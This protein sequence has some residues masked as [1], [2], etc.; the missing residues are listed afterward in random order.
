MPAA[1]STLQPPDSRF[2][3]STLR[4]SADTAPPLRPLLAGTL[5]AVAVCVLAA[6]FDTGRLPLPSR[7]VFWLVLIGWNSAK[8]WMWY[9]WV[10]PRAVGRRG[11]LLLALAGT[12][13]LNAT[14]PLEIDLMFRAIGQPVAL[15]WLGLYL[16]ALVI[17][18]SISAFIAILRGGRP[19]AAPAPDAQPVAPP[20]PPPTTSLLAP[21]LLAQR[22]GLPDLADVRHVVAEDHYLRLVLAD[23]RRPLVLFR[24]GDALPEL[25]V[26]DGCQVH[27]SAWVAAAHVVGARR[28]GRRWLLQLAD[29]SEQAVSETHLPAVRAAGWLR[30]G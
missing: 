2:V 4:L 1:S 9:A 15:R 29:G 14:L 11:A 19:L 24:L 5:F 8:W 12:L 26:L 16:S 7:L 13:L 18:G 20:A 22:A 23:G 17:A 30:R 10:G 6:P 21:S 28:D 27:R 3:E 25:A